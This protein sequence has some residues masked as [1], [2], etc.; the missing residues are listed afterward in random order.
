MTLLVAIGLALVSGGCE[1]L[2]PSVTCAGIRSLRLGMTEDEVVARVGTPLIKGGG[3]RPNSDSWEYGLQDQ[4]QFPGALRF[5]VRFE[6]GKL[7]LAVAGRR[8]LFGKRRDY[9]VLHTSYSREEPGFA[10]MFCE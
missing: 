10:E 7:V 6:N 9:F 2:S 8:P 1:G 3:S 4:E 5:D